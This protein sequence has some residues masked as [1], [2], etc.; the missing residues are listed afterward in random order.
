[1]TR[2]QRVILCTP[3]PYLPR[4][5]TSIGVYKRDSS[6]AEGFEVKLEELRRRNVFAR[7]QLDLFEKT[8]PKA[9]KKLE[10]IGE[11]VCV[12]WLCSDQGC[13]GHEM[14]ILDWEI[15]Q[16]ARKEGFEKAKKKSECS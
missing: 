4:Q 1:M 12:N 7:N 15:C 3:R 10:F 11:R 13:G 14:Q 2:G 5:I 8:V 16:L 9:M 6:D